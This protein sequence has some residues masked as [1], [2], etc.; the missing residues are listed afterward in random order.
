MMKFRTIARVIWMCAVAA[1]ALPARIDA[2]AQHGRHHHYKLFDLGSFGG[3]G[4]PAGGFNGSGPSFGQLNDRGMSVGALDSATLDPNG[5]NMCFFDCFVDISFVWHDGVVTPL[6]SLPGGEDLSSYASSINNFGQITGAAQNGATDPLTGWPSEIRAVLWQ[7]GQIVN[8]GTLGG[9][10]SSANAINDLGQVVGGSLTK[11]P[12]PFANDNIA[13]CG[14][15][16]GLPF[17][18]NALAVPGTTET[19]AF[20]WQKGSMRD[21][22]TLGGPDSTAW[23][24]NDRGEVAGESFISYTANASTGVPTVDPFFWS[25][26]GG[27]MIDLGGLGGTCGWTVWLNNQGQVVGFSNPPGDQTE[28]PFIWSK[29]QGMVD[30]FLNGGLGG[31]FG[32]P[33]WIN[34]VGEVVGYATI[35]EGDEDGHGFLW[36]NGVITDLGTVGTDPDSEGGS[37]NLAGQ[38]VGGSGAFF[39]QGG[40]HRGVLWENGEP[41]VD[42]NTLVLPG[43]GMNIINADFINDHGEIACT[44]T[45]AAVPQEHPCMLIPCDENH[46]DV[47]GCD[48]SLVESAPPAEVHASQTDQAVASAVSQPKLSQAEIVAR[49]RELMAARRRKFGVPYP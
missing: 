13:A 21:L 40:I 2:Q 14:I 38:I 25:P 39:V 45:T 49:Y 23:I 48:Y 35:Q 28:H 15:Y 9:N 26:E 20:I 33:D 42:L 34:D 6:P 32:H 46:L 16:A 7:R 47:E 5:P 36:R 41:I 43:T 4:A 29:S 37:I 11:T 8:L 44:G 24:I 27:K 1:L 17:T 31:T 3:P 30:L 12:D 19:H 10:E 18:F 22:H